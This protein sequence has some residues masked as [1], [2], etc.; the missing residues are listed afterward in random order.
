MAVP[1]SDPPT[2]SSQV[3]EYYRRISD[4]INVPI[5]MQDVPNAPVP[6]TLAVQIAQESQQACYAKVETPPT[7]PRVAEARELGG[8][9]LI[10]FGGAGGSFFLE[11]LRRGSR[12]TM[13]GTTIPD[14]FRRVWDLYHGGR[15]R[16][17]AKEFDRYL[18]CSS[19][20]A[21]ALTSHIT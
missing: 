16:E 8:D 6:P 2:T 17:A 15:E 12:G 3:R 7:P 9:D 1:P 21:R 4:A 20:S 18:P 14:V 19:R 11:E 5:F 10:V 13:P